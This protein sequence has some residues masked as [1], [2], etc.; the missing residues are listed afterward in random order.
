[1][2]RKLR[3]TG[4]MR[5]EIAFPLRKEE[6]RETGG[7]EETASLYYNVEEGEKQQKAVILRFQR[8]TTLPQTKVRRRKMLTTLRFAN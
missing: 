5:R 8:Q 2:L 4:I 1:M 6:E 7:G 3:G